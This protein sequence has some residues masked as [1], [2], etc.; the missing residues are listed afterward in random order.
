MDVQKIKIMLCWVN[1]LGVLTQKIMYGK[2]EGNSPSKIVCCSKNENWG[3]KLILIH[4]KRS[5]S[6][7]EPN[8]HGRASRTRQGKP[9]LH[10]PKRKERLRRAHKSV[11]TS[12]LVTPHLV[13]KRLVKRKRRTRRVLRKW[14]S[15]RDSLYKMV[16][17]LCEK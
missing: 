1:E 4:R 8:K 16:C 6:T 17:I 2:N 15:T 7:H 3:W 12:C 14:R 10:F 5:T 11:V 9:T 13:I